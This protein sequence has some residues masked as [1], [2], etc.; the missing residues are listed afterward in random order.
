MEVRKSEPLVSKGAVLNIRCL[1]SSLQSRAAWMQS[2]HDE[3]KDP[4]GMM[5]DIE[6]IY[7]NHFEPHYISQVSTS[8]L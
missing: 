1:E 5:P 2:L 3:A 8:N 4:V 6:A 7:V